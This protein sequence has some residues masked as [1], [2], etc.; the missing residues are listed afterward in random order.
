MID[1]TLFWE[2]HTDK[3]LPRLNQACYKIRAVKPFVSQDILKMIYYDNFHSVM[4]Y[5]LLFS[6][7]SSHSMEVFGLQKKIIRIMMG[8]RSRDFFKTLGILP[9]T[10]QYI[11][12]TT[13]FVV[14]NLKYFTENSELYDIKTRKTRTYFNHNKT[15]LSIKWV[16]IMLASRYIL[17][18]L[19]Q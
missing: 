13:M 17:I 15:H 8:S 11:Y 10:A 5:G 14:N 16:L 19:L 4:T 18:F 7:K 1:N 6:G 3:I 2:G 9:F 12:T